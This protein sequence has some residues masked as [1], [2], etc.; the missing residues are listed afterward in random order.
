M[1]NANSSLLGIAGAS[2]MAAS[3]SLRVMPQTDSCGYNVFVGLT[4]VICF[5][6][7]ETLFLSMWATNPKKTKDR[8]CIG[9][10]SARK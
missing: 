5:G 4:L 1:C 3:W 7:V 6:D 10:Y 2:L 9:K 8:V